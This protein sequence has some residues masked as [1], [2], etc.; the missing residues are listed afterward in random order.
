MHEATIIM[1]HAHPIR[2]H[3]ITSLRWQSRSMLVV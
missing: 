3:K 1:M 2:P